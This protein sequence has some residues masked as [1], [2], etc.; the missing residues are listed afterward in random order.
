MPAS[1][2]A[3]L[4]HHSDGFY[5]GIDPLGGL[6]SRFGGYHAYKGLAEIRAFRA[7]LIQELPVGSSGSSA[8]F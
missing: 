1:T 4:D 3:V 7:G 8:G 5:Q 6:Y 2:Q